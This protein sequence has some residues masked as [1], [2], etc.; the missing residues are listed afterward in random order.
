MFKFLNYIKKILFPSI[1][2]TL[3]QYKAVFVTS[4]GKTR[5]SKC[6]RWGNPQGLRCSV[7]DYLLSCVEFLEDKNGIKYPIYN[8][9]SIKF[10]L[11]RTMECIV[12][13]TCGYGRG[14]ALY[15]SDSKYIV[16]IIKINSE[17]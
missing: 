8:I 5:E 10:I 4:D 1:K 17:G 2:L 3:E 9:I 16:K 14:Y 11:V 15:D 12:K 13:D 6:F 7:P